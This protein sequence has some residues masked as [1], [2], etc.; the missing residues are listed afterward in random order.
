[1]K[2]PPKFFIYIPVKSYVKRF[3]ELNYGS[4]VD[5]TSDTDTNQRF[6]QF[7][8]KP[9]TSRNQHYPEKMKA[10]NCELEVVISEYYF[11]KYGF[12]LSRTDVVSFNQLFGRRAKSLMRSIVGMYHG[13]GLPYNIAIRKFQERFGFTEDD[14]SFEAIKKDFYR[15]GTENP[16]D[17]DGEIFQKI[18]KIILYNL[19]DLG[20]ICKPLIKNYENN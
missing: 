4:P 12:E 1:M 15:N 9:D 17:F 7:I 3:V 5:F 13:V 2:Q 8:S 14:W 11:Y 10:Y 16:I 6:L 19:Y 20:T 18:E